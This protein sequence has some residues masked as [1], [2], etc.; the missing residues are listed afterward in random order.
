MLNIVN[1]REDEWFRPEDFIIP[2]I[3]TIDSSAG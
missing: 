1:P 2:P 3:R